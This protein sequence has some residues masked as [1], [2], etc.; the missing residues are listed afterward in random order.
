MSGIN[1]E[2]TE[3]TR[4]GFVAIVGRPNAG[5]STLMNAL[6]GEKISMVSQKA[7]ATRKRI[8]AIVMHK[9]TRSSLLTPPVFMKKRRCSIS[10]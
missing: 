5:K 4:A 10:L 1:T 2:A 8:N 3:E 9:K 6:L 7:N